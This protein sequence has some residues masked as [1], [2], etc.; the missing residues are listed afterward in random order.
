VKIGYIM[1]RGDDVKRLQKALNFPETEIDGVFGKKTDIAVREFQ[2]NH[3]LNVDGKVGPATWA[4][5]GDRE[6]S[7]GSY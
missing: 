6:T 3:G 4:E 2:K 1:M 7:L 5:L